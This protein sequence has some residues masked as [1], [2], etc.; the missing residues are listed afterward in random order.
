MLHL[1]CILSCLDVFKS[2][3]VLCWI[4]WLLLQGM[5]LLWFRAESVL[6]YVYW[7]LFSECCKFIDILIDSRKVLMWIVTCFI[8]TVYIYLCSIFLSHL[9]TPPQCKFFFSYDV[10]NINV[11]IIISRVI[12]FHFLSKQ[13]R[14]I[15]FTENLQPLWLTKSFL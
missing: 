6:V 4:P 1:E 9:F 7:R 11:I 13:L 15:Q 2:T 8:Y 10:W 14:A 3:S 12:P 5:R